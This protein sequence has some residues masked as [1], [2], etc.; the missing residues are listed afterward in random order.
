MRVACG[1]TR[2]PRVDQ[3]K[4]F[5][6][7]VREVKI[8]NRKGSSGWLYRIGLKALRGRSG[9]LSATSFLNIGEE[10]Q[11]AKAWLIPNGIIERI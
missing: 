2:K 11:R 10:H 8:P 1:E 3:P 9:V 6:R 5:E 7:Y 4:R